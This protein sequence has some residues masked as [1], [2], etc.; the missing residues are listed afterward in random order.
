MKI[1]YY[2]WTPL[3]VPRIGGGVAVYLENLINSFISS[4]GGRKLQFSL[5]DITMIK[6]VIHT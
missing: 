3:H 5:Q 1:L 4:G 6:S 2:N